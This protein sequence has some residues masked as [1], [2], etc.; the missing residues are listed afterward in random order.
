[1]TS[2]DDYVL[3]ILTENQLVTQDAAD[4]ATSK[5]AEEGASAVDELVKSGAL[6]E[7]DVLGTLASTFGMQFLD[8]SQLE[9]NDSVRELLPGELAKKFKVVPLYE[10][11]GTLT[12]AMADPMNFETLDSLRSVLGKDTGRDMKQVLLHPIRVGA[13]SKLDHL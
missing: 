3:Q 6:T 5:G 9:M 7:N 13:D 12:V 10:T 8:I 11:N 4:A 2:N 1:M